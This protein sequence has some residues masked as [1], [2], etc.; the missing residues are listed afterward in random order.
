MMDRLQIQVVGLWIRCQRA[1]EL[2]LVLG[3]GCDTDAVTDNRGGDLV[4]DGQ[5][6]RLRAIEHVAPEA[7]GP[8]D[9]DQFGGDEKPSA[10]RISEPVRT[11]SALSCRP[12]ACGS[13]V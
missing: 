12:M 5:H 7:R 13:I 10:R 9:I 3:F 11:T 4:V 8:R 6:V 1:R 2:A